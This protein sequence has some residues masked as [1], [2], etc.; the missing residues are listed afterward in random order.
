MAGGEVV[1][2]DEFESL[3][4]EE[5]A[6][7]DV[8]S[9]GQQTAL[10]E[11]SV[12]ALTAAASGNG[13]DGGKSN[14]KA[15]GRNRDEEE[16]SDSDASSEDSDNKGSSSTRRQRTILQRINR[17]IDRTK[18]A[19]ARSFVDYG[20]PYATWEIDGSLNETCSQPKIKI[21][22]LHSLLNQRGKT[23]QLAYLGACSLPYAQLVSCL[24]APFLQ[25][26][27]FAQPIPTSRTPRTCT[28]HPYIGALETPIFWL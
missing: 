2:A 22:E 4:A 8:A 20:P 18:R 27:M 1:T 12:Q 14:G 25:T 23:G 26:L 24:H 13:A 15:S 11:G 5:L 16:L 6:E 17:A 3:L 7:E 10:T 28:I 19:F 21:T 9:L